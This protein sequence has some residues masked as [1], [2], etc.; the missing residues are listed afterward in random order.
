MTYNY[1]QVIDGEVVN[2]AVFAEAPDIEF[3]KTTGGEWVLVPEGYPVGIGNKWDGWNFLS[4]DGAVIKPTH[5][6]FF[7]NT[8]N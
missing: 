6:I 3:V 8:D 7:E 4:E 2:I 1:A 5:D